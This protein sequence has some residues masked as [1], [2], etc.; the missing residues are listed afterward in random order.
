MRQVLAAPQAGAAGTAGEGQ[1][2]LGQLAARALL[3][4]RAYATK[5]AEAVLAGGAERAGVGCALVDVDAAVRS[6]EATRALA[7]EPVD[8]VHASPTVEAGRRA[9][10]V[11]VTLAAFALEA[12]AANALEATEAARVSA[13][14]RVRV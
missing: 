5:L 8:A 2:Q 13:V 3:T 4:R 7:A 11:H 12:L 9:A 10:V 1:V 14:R 6:G